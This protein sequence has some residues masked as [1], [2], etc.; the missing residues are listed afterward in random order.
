[1][2][3]PIVIVAARQRGQDPDTLLKLAGNPPTRPGV[4]SAWADALVAMAGRVPPATTLQAIEMFAADTPRP[5]LRERM[6]SASLEAAPPLAERPNPD[7]YPALLLRRAQVRRSMGQ[8]ELALADYQRLDQ[9][10]EA[11]DPATREL[12][13][14]GM[15]QCYLETNQVS[16]A[17]AVAR[18]F[19][20]DPDRPGSLRPDVANDPMMDEIVA[21]A[22]RETELGR[23]Q[24]AR[25]ILDN[26]RLLLGP[27]AGINAELDRRIQQV[28]SAIE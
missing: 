27:T 14:R 5:T 25:R 17:F 4:L 6:L 22:R 18:R 1:V 13:S 19:F 7:P 12:I 8:T 9:R 3:Q 2:V 16:E 23:D 26:L 21:A 10:R 15:V 24:R 28:E 11:L 20:A